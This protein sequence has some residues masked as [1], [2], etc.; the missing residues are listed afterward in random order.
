[1]QVGVSLSAPTPTVS[2]T[3]G[4]QG[5]GRTQ[6]GTIIPLEGDEAAWS[7]G[8]EDTVLSLL[9]PR[10]TCMGEAAVPQPSP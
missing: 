10:A 8:G 5:C 7:P 6:R 4:P 9:C 1:M 3:P 2:A